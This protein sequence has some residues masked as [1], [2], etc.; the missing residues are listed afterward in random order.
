[1]MKDQKLGE[2]STLVKKTIIRNRVFI[3][4]QAQSPCRSEL[5]ILF[6]WFSEANPLCHMFLALGQKN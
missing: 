4:T 2:E 3:A 5:C 1:M 6:F